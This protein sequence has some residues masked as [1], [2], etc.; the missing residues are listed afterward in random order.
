MKES[1]HIHILDMMRGLAALGVVLTHYAGMG[2]LGESFLTK[3]FFQG[4]YGVHVFFVISGFVIPWSLR[5]SNF[6]S[7]HFFRFILR[8][9][10]RIDPPYYITLSLLLLI[11][12][13]IT[14]RASYIGS[15]FKFEFWRFLSHFMYLIPF[16]EYHFYDLVFW[17][18]AIE[19][20]YYIFIAIVFSLLISKKK[21]THR[22]FIIAY[23]LSIFLPIQNTYTIFYYSGLFT[24]GI[25]IFLFKAGKII[26]WEYVLASVLVSALIYYQLGMEVCIAGVMSILLIM[27]V[28]VRYKVTDFLGKISYSLYLTH[29]IV[30]IFL[31]SNFAKNL[32]SLNGLILSFKLLYVSLMVMVAI[33]F[34]YCFYLVV[35]RPSMLL[36]KKIEY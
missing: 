6:Q 24:L 34:A 22:L 31:F 1:S 36:A 32:F 20:Q 8:R 7:K 14:V 5:K 4:N 17:T 9:S 11:N 26:V 33:G 18:L 15:V 27:L 13:L 28:D 19:F 16:T 10:L 21:I 30:R 23:S 29:N 2:F 25:L 3:L 12:Y 35:E